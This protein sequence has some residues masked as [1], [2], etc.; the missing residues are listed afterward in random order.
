V[1][2]YTSDLDKAIRTPYAPY[3]K[4]G[5]KDGE[6]YKQINANILQIENEFYS[7]IRPKRVPKGNERPT[8]ALRRRGVEYIEMRS[9]DLNPFEA[10]GLN[11][12]QLKFLDAFLVFCLLEDNIQTSET[13][14]KISKKNI[15]TVVYEGR[16]N[17]A[18]IIDSHTEKSSPLASAANLLLD[19]ISQVAELFDTQLNKGENSYKTSVAEERKKIENPALTASG[20]IIHTLETESISFFE[21]A[22]EQATQHKQSFMSASLSE[23]KKTQMQALAKQSIEEQKRI[24]AADNIDFDSFVANYFKN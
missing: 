9:L 18:Q 5:I 6:Q 3:E 16:S 10:L 4:I 24:E 20:K 2:S 12:S 8:Q 23:E 13:M 1:E 14:M 17:Q 7:N 15:Q 21:F 11:K 19:K 22:M